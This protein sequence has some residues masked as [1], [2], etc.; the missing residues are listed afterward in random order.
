MPVLTFDHAQEATYV[1]GA[2]LDINTS[3]GVTVYSLAAQF[4]TECIVFYQTTVVPWLEARGMKRG[5]G[6]IVNHQLIYT[7]DPVNPPWCGIAGLEKYLSK[8][9]PPVA[10][11][12]PYE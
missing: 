12:L 3:N 4:E 1:R 8:E 5:R 10:Q 9:H 11:E 7:G 6:W 2:N